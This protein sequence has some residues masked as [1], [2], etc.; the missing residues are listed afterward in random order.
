MSRST[1]A[2]LQLQPFFMVVKAQIQRDEERTLMSGYVD[3]TIDIPDITSPDVKTIQFYLRN[4]DVAQWGE[5]WTLLYCCN[6][7]AY[8]QVGQYGLLVE[9]ATVIGSVEPPEGKK[10]TPITKLPF[11]QEVIENK[12]IAVWQTPPKT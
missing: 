7:N 11:N 3:R 1:S 4:D 2:V 6:V 8:L 5:P 12:K 10:A 9:K